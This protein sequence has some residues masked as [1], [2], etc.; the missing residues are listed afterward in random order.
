MSPIAASDFHTLSSDPIV[1]SDNSE[2]STDDII[3]DVLF[4]TLPTVAF[5]QGLYN[6]YLLNQHKRF[7]N[8]TLLCFYFFAIT[9]LIGKFHNL[10]I[11]IR[12]DSLRIETCD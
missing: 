12:L 7:R 2:I 11:G 4:V 8:K 9:A 5:C 6:I 1:T 10:F 3:I